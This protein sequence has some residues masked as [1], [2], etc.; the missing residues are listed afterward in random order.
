[1]YISTN[2]P[3]LSSLFKPSSARFKLTLFA[4]IATFI[5]G[6]CSAPFNWRIVRADDLAYEAL[7]P[8]KPNRAQRTL[9]INGVNYT[10]T[11]EAA[12]A[13]DVVFAVGTI[14][15]KK[16]ELNG[17]EILNWLKA[18]TSKSLGKNVQVEDLSEISFS[19]A[20]SQGLVMPATGIKISGVGPDQLMKE[21]Q[22]RWVRR[23][24]EAGIER[25]YQVTTLQSFETQ[26]A[27][28][29]QDLLKEHIETFYAGFH[30]Y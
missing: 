6:A 12:K 1:M 23:I 15:L 20:G 26:A 4:L 10:M 24:D 16:D 27:N 30:P 5:L 22:V 3:Q 28:N 11:M 7:Y 25:I 2:I 29:Q 17:N 8:S 19:V 21:L 14:E 13:Q 18:N 9:T